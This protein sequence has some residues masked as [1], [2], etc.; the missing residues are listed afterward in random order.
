VMSVPTFRRVV[1]S[2]NEYLSCIGLNNKLICALDEVNSLNLIT[3][4]LLNELTSECV[5]VS[6]VT[7]LL[8]I[9]KIMKY[10]FI[11]IYLQ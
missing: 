10:L 2:E 3:Q 6:S 4:L 5:M 7:R 11:G 8:I 9:K 1:C